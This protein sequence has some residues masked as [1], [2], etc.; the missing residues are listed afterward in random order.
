MIY[1]IWYMMWQIN[2]WSYSWMLLLVL[3]WLFLYFVVL[4]ELVE[5]LIKWMV[6]DFSNCWGYSTTKVKVTW[7]LKYV[8]IWKYSVSW[9][10][11]RRFLKWILDNLLKDNFLW[12]RGTEW[13]GACT[14]V[15]F[16]KFSW[17]FPVTS[18]FWSAGSS[19]CPLNRISTTR[20]TWCSGKIVLFSKNLQCFATSP[21]QTLGC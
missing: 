5:G 10:Q 18:I 20:Y 12:W 16:F 14:R 13:C 4:P 21:S 6:K 9:S 11:N 17:N 8:F 19:P 2:C 7:T 1:D 3:F 15:A